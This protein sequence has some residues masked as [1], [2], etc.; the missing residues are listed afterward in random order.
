MLHTI[1]FNM[2]V[3]E[4]YFC[5]SG[6]TE[7][8]I[9]D[10]LK[11]VRYRDY[12]LNGDERTAVYKAIHREREEW[13]NDEMVPCIETVAR[14]RAREDVIGVRAEER[15]AATAQR[16]GETET[17]RLAAIAAREAAAEARKREAEQR[18]QDAG[19][20]RAARARPPR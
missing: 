7:Q 17:K 6:I 14:R 4:R 1:L 16:R 20:A 11:E 15:A 3:F 19:A 12:A 9:A 5:D 18:R 8:E 2:K 13:Q 10:F